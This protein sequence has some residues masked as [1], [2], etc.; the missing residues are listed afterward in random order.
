MS[1]LQT[2]C[3]SRKTL[4]QGTQTPAKKVILWSRDLSKAW[5]AIWRSV[6]RKLQASLWKFSLHCLLIWLADSSL[7]R[8]LHVY[9]TWPD[10]THNTSPVLKTLFWLLPVM[11]LCWFCKI[12]FMTL[13][14]VHRVRP[15]IFLVQ[16]LLSATAFSL[17]NLQSYRNRTWLILT[18]EILCLLISGI[19][20]CCA[21][22]C[23]IKSGLGFCP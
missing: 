3:A 18:C 8:I 2:V 22:E 23:L 12:L 6:S 21:S 1:V 20:K 5:L 17:F 11:N 13:K 9:T 15:F 16:L 4:L 10:L 19:L 14:L 7:F